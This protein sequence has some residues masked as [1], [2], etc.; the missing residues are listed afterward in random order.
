MVHWPFRHR[1]L[2]EF[3]QSRQKGFF[4]FEKKELVLTR[5]FERKVMET[6]YDLSDHRI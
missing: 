2:A 5:T 1:N 3:G 4:F 6:Y